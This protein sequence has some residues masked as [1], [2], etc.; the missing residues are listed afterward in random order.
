MFTGIIEETGRIGAIRTSADGA[1]M[2]VRA[3]RV[4]GGTKE[5]DSIAVN[6]TCLTVTALSGG[7]FDVDMA[8]ETLSR[9]NLGDLA[10]GD[11]VN[12]ERSLTP[13]ARLGGHFVQGHVDSTGTLRS[14]RRDGESLRVEISL[15]EDLVRYLAPKGYVA[16][17]GV[18]LTVV[19]VRDDGFSIMLV[20]YTLEHITLPDKT[21]G[22]SVNVE[23]DILAKYVERMLGL[24][25]ADVPSVPES[26]DRSLG[27]SKSFLEENGYG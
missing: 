27:I 15:S 17:D 25:G 6:G 12:L 7:S 1:K 3:N 24:K 20:P 4:L 11:A 13:D 22:E 5:G 16:V 2:T 8:P 21:I 9:T 18:S 14:M 10:V 26:S 19:N 23:V